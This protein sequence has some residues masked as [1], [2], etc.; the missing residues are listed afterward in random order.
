[1]SDEK[2]V[3]P[4]DGEGVMCNDCPAIY[5]KKSCDLMPV[6][7]E[8]QD[9]TKDVIDVLVM[10]WGKKTV[11]DYVASIEERQVSKG[12]GSWLAES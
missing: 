4:C 7:E 12:I 11:L 6:V 2:S 3:A 10:M 1:M 8:M 9:K 5:P